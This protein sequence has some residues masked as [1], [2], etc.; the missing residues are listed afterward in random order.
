MTTLS[1]CSAG[2][3]ALGAGWAAASTLDLRI[4]CNGMLGGIVAATALCAFVEPW[5]GAVVGLLAGGATVG[6]SAAMSAAGVDDPLDSVAVH[7]APAVVGLVS[8]AFLA[9]P[10]LLTSLSGADPVCGGLVYA[11]RAVGWTQLW[12]QLVGAAAVAALSAGAA[13][14]TFGALRAGGRLRV[15]TAAEVAGIDHVDHGGPAYPDFE[16]RTREW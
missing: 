1:A 12:V 11:G 14:A 6:A 10:A 16:L 4:A 5:A 2:L 13:A 7:A 3:A 9:R 15:D 8:A